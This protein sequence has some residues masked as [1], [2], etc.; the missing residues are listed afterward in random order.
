PQALASI[1]IG[2]SNI[3]AVVTDAK[4]NTSFIF[5]ASNDFNIAFG[6]FT[7]GEVIDASSVENVAHFNFP[8]NVYKIKATLNQDNKWSFEIDS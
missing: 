4:P 8:T 7:Q 6:K 2:M 3:A 1:G 5:Y